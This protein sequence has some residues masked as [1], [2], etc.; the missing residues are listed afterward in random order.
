MGGELSMW[1]SQ[2]VPE[3]YYHIREAT[4]RSSGTWCLR[5]WCLIIIIIISVAQTINTI[6]HNIWR[7]NYYYQTPHPSTPDTCIFPRTNKKK[8]AGA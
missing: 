8:P 1:G 4:F 2:F 6:Y 7:L 3:D 5:M